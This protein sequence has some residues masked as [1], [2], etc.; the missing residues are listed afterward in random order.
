MWGGPEAEAAHPS[1]LESSPGSALPWSI[2]GDSKLGSHE[3]HHTYEESCL[4]LGNQ[5]QCPA[6][7]NWM[8]PF[9]WI[10]LAWF[11]PSHNIVV[12]WKLK[13]DLCKLI[14]I[15]N[16]M[17]ILACSFSGEWM[18]AIPP[19]KQLALRFF[20]CE[21]CSKEILFWSPFPF[22]CLLASGNSAVWLL[23]AQNVP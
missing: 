13:S 21:H 16:S 14:K 9:P 1:Q 3:Q 10:V 12:H 18:S 22:S 6:W 23:P 17:K 4:L 20:S 7:I 11:K 15:T 2:T 8:F 5:V 19:P